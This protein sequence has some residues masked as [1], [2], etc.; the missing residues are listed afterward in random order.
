MCIRSLNVGRNALRSNLL[1]WYMNKC[2][3]C[4]MMHLIPSLS[5]QHYVAPWINSEMI[6]DG[7]SDCGPQLQYSSY[8][9]TGQIHWF[10]CPLASNGFHVWFLTDLYSLQSVST[11]LLPIHLS[12]FSLGNEYYQ[13]LFILI[14][15]DSCSLLSDS[16]NKHLCNVRN[17]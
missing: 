9:R 14:L 17:G 15:S 5:E 8:C 1:T 10:I 13:T 16:N 12:Q 4:Q 6:F 7:C 3:I 11:S 2:K